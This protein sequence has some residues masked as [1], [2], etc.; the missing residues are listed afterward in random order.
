MSAQD[1]D[2]AFDL[3]DRAGVLSGR[4]KPRGAVHRDGDWH[5]ALHLWVL[6]VRGRTRHVVLQRRS[7]AKDTHPGLVDVSV[8]G[9]L[10]AGES[11]DDA[12]REAEEEIGLRVS[13]A[14][15]VLL[16]HRRVEKVVPAG[17]DRE[18]QT[19]LATVTDRVFAQLR[20]HPEEVAALYAPTLADALS[21]ARGEV[22]SIGAPCLDARRYPSF[23]Q[24]RA[25]DFIPGDEAYRRRCLE[26][27]DAHLRGEAFPLMVLD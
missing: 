19:V 1:L 12:L 24:L 5:R 2:E 8:A 16:G 20:P 11:V 23:E 22:P 15:T 4:V 17:I 13:P 3:C 14:D 25:A 6:L 21:L 26:S 18:V 27:L 9:H 7:H 10:G